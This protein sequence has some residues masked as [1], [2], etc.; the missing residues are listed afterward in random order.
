MVI[1]F[2]AI[3]YTCHIRPNCWQF[4][5]K[6]KTGMSSKNIQKSNSSLKFAEKLEYAAWAGKKKFSYKIGE[7]KSLVLIIPYFIV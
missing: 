5:P 4:A 3:R 2:L 1:T 7:C 6:I